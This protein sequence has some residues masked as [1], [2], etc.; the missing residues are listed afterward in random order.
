M[1]R[2]LSALLCL[3]LILALA[4]PA[5]AEAPVETDVPLETEAPPERITTPEEFLRFAEACALESYS[6]GRVFSLETD[7]TL[8]A[9]FAPIPYFAGTFLG[10]GHRIEGLDLRGDGSRLGLFRTL[11]EGARVCDLEVSGSVCPGGTRINVGGLAGVNGGTIEN[12]SFSGTVTALENVGGLVGTNG[13]SGAILSCRFEGEVRAEHQS[14]GVAGKNLGLIEKCRNAGAVNNVSITP[15]R[16]QSFDLAAF[17]EDDFLDLADI[18][19][20]AGE[21]DGV[22]R[23]CVNEGPVGY[24]N[25]GYNVGGVAGKSSGYVTACE[26]RGPVRGRRDVGGI[27]GQL[28]PH[29]VWDFSEDRLNGITD[30]LEKLD[31]LLSSGSHGAEVRSGS[32]RSHLNVLHGSV[33][34]ALDELRGVMSYYTGAAGVDPGS[35]PIEIDPETGLPTVPGV[36][37]TGADLD[38]LTQALDRVYTESAA[39]SEEL[40]DDMLAASDYLRSVNAQITRVLDCMGGMLGTQRQGELIEIYDLSADETWEHDPGAVDGCYNAGSVEAESSAGGIAGSMAF[41]LSFDMEDNLNASDFVSSDAKRYLFA[42]LRGCESRGEVTVRADC[43]GGVVGRAEAGAVVDC[44]GAAA[45]RSLKGD[46][47]GGIAGSSDGVI[48]ACWARGV[49]GGGKYVG[50]VA[51]SGLTVLDCAS[52]VSIERGAEYLGAVAG[53]AEGEISGNRYAGEGPAGVDGVS[54]EGQCEP[55]EVAALL[56]LDGAPEGFDELVLRFYVGERL[57]EERKIPFGSAAGELPAVPDEGARRWRW[58]N[59]DLEHV[60][61]SM[62]VRGSYTEPVTVLSSGEEPPLFLVE[63]EF[64]EDQRLTVSP[65][66]FETEEETLAAAALSVEGYEGALTVHLRAEGGGRLFLVETDGT[67]RELPFEVDKSYLVFSLDNGASFVYLRGESA[68]AWI[69]WAAG[70]GAALLLA[71]ILLIRHRRKKAAVKAAAEHEEKA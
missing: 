1:K 15:E 52:W 43:A 3:L 63:G 27:V 60:Y 48:R 30:E 45:V 32:V 58:E 50:G 24:P 21:N 18:G 65:C 17:T 59:F 22:I 71:A 29:A 34:D 67:L 4:S 25:T 55:V 16:K 13:E 28:I 31:E 46:Y 40:S 12:C 5:L 20:V 56:A 42:A 6:K 61:R 69:P 41:E 51:G 64:T 19:G 11:A 23:D 8:G 2:I 47:V 33:T 44:V 66:G 9:D 14:G 39:L 35:L 62:D 53:W 36:S 49:L 54:L 7:L 68:P 37:L 57:V 70:G 26:N 10:N 38:G